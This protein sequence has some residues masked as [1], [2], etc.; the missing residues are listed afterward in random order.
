MR[1]FEDITHVVLYCVM[2]MAAI[3]LLVV[4]AFQ[5]QKSE[6]FNVAMMQGRTTVREAG[7]IQSEGLKS[8]RVVSSSNGQIKAVGAYRGEVL[9]SILSSDGSYD[10]T[11]NGTTLD[12]T[13]VANAALGDKTQINKISALLTGDK[14]MKHYNYTFTNGTG[15]LIAVEYTTAY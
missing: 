10:I 11:I 9:T 6:S 14:Y 1:T 12:K 2:W 15:K 8:N 4:M 5:V 13:D 3:T 7:D